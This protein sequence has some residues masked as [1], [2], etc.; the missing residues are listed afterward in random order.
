MKSEKHNPSPETNTNQELNLRRASVRNK[1]RFSIHQLDELD[2]NTPTFTKFETVF[3][4]TLTRENKTAGRHL[5]DADWVEA[6]TTLADK[7]IISEETAIVLWDT[8]QEIRDERND[9]TK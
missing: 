8:T 3:I 1:V 4:N 9:P 7:G 6:L 2:S 5:A